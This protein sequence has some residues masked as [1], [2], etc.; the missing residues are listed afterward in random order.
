MD[1]FNN[2]NRE[3]FFSTICYFIFELYQMS[4]ATL[5]LIFIP[6]KCNDNVCNLEEKIDFSSNSFLT[7]VTYINI[8]SLLFF[9]LLYFIEY[10]RE[11]NIIKILDVNPNNPTNTVALDAIFSTLSEENKFK[12]VNIQILYGTLFYFSLVIFCIN[13]ICSFIIISDKSLG[14]ETYIN[15]FTNLAFI[16]SKIYHILNITYVNKNIYYSAYMTSY[17]LFNDVDTEYK[18]KDNYQLQRQVQEIYH[19]ATNYKS[20][21]NV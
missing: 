19:D 20:I 5:Y 3:M 10:Y 17:V 11:Y 16:S 12:L 7:F 14:Y 4:T 6:Q 13:T 9:I 8:I 21:N 1:F 18:T 2:Q 15:F